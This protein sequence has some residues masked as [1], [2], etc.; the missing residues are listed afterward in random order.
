MNLHPQDLGQENYSL[1]WGGFSSSSLWLLYIP[2]ML[3]NWHKV[4][5]TDLRIW[6]RSTLT[7]EH[8]LSLVL[9]HVNKLLA[10]FSQANDVCTFSRASLKYKGKGKGVLVYVVISPIGNLKT[11]VSINKIMQAL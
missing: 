5:L 6:V 10:L 8:I 9:V 7:A 2:F 1:H 11:I 3:F 4:N